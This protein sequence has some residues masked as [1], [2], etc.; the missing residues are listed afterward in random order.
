VTA[1]AAP[2]KAAHGQRLKPLHR[3]RRIAVEADGR[4]QP[5]AVQVGSRRVL[6][7][8]IIETWRIDDEWWRDKPVSRVY[9]RVALEDGRVVDVYRD[10]ISRNWWRQAY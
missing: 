6:I 2:A 1:P 8:S 3:P 9:W 7:E 10:L 4:D 5:I